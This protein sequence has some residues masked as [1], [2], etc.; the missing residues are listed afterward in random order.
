MAQQQH[1]PPPPMSAPA[2]VTSFPGPPQAPPP[3]FSYPPPPTQT[4]PANTHYPGPPLSVS[5]PAVSTTPN[6]KQANLY[7]QNF[8]QN[9][10]QNAAAAQHNHSMMPGAPPPGQFTGA[11]STSDDNVGTFNGGS[12]RISH[13][14]VN[15]LLTLQ[16][17]MGCPLTAKP[18]VMIAMSTTMT[19]R[20][21]V[22]FGWK[23][24]LAGGEMT[25]SQYTGPG[26][27]LIAPSV[28]GDIIV[29]RLN[30]E[31][32]WKI[33]RDSFL[34]STASVRHK[35]QAQGITKAVFSGEGLFIYKISG[36]GLL[37]LQSFG[38]IIKKD[39]KEGETYFIDNG[40]LVAWNCKYE[41]ER[42]ASGGI[43]SGLSSGEGLACKFKGPGTVY[44]QTRNLNAFAAQMKAEYSSAWHPRQNTEPSFGF[45]ISFKKLP[46]LIA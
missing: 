9:F 18:G 33:G 35:Y 34:A 29:L 32:E 16:L 3:N 41:I 19:L 14:D 21:T 44:L 42:V 40:H 45:E 23:K 17:A 31:E 38:A 37:W 39:L 24:L 26:E 1:Y 43:V 15:S 11:T 6:E 28:L 20:G 8:H 27:L 46:S 10:H 30:G 12:Y 36:T 4:P 7:Q 22:H 13:R 5:P 2:H 25:M